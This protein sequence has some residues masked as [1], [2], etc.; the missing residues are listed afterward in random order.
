MVIVGVMCMSLVFRV[1]MF[2]LVFFVVIFVMVVVVVCI[3]LVVIIGL[4]VDD[5]LVLVWEIDDVFL[6]W[7]GGGFFFGFFF[8][9]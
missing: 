1:F 4:G 6:L 2:I 7:V 5:M 3:D 9:I 8:I